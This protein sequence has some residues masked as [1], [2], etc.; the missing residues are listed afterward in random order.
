MSFDEDLNKIKGSLSQWVEFKKKFEEEISK[1]PENVNLKKRLIKTKEKIK[2]YEE[3]IRKL[4]NTNLSSGEDSE[5]DSKEEPESKRER[6]KRLAKYGF[7]KTWKGAK[8]AHRKIKDGAEKSGLTESLKGA[9]QEFKE[10]MTKNRDIDTP[11]KGF[12]SSLKSATSNNPGTAKINFFFILALSIHV[13][14]GYL[15]FDNFAFRVVGYFLL[16]LYGGLIVFKSEGNLMGAAS[17]SG[18]LALA[19]FFIPLFM[20]QLLNPLMSWT[21]VNILRVCF[22]VYFIYFLSHPIT[23]LLE[24]IKTLTFWFWLIL[25]ILYLFVAIRFGTLESIPFLSVLDSEILEN[26]ED[27]DAGGAWNSLRLFIGGIFVD[28][29]EST[30]TMIDEK[31]NKTNSI[32]NEQLDY[33]TGGLYSGKE[34]NA[35]KQGLFIEDILFSQPS[36]EEYEKPIEVSANIDIQ[37]PAES[38]LFKTECDTK[39]NQ[40]DA[41]VFQGEILE[42]PSG[43]MMLGYS[44]ELLPLTCSFKDGLEK[45]NYDVSFKVT[46][47]Y[48]TASS[49]KM[50]FIDKQRKN[51]M[52]AENID[53]LKHYGKDSD[54]QA[55]YTPGP[56]ELGIKQPTPPI[57]LELNR[58][59]GPLIGFTIKNKWQGEISKINFIYIYTPEGLDLDTTY[60]NQFRYISTENNFNVYLMEDPEKFPTIDDYTT[61]NCKTKINSKTSLLGN[62]EISTKEIKVIVSYVFETKK[63]TDLRVK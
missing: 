60:C 23:P 7:K 37:I 10:G 53:P 40:E 2:E 22:P 20:V 33:A 63:S 17:I 18:L 26:Q 16:F 50:Y 55:I 15:N 13:I 42:T 6:V 27:A 32:K 4:E 3:E 51:A 14:D 44:N 25:F 1:D 48:E 54:P 39:I 57:A 30:K 38:I 11:V 34:E 8:W 21:L 24:K 49:L 19:G 41:A 28:S 45:G 61:I 47:D 58:E 62:D 31:I 52:R 43:E 12:F 46:Y 59:L 29:W 36:Y 56:I 5:E 35:P 9:K